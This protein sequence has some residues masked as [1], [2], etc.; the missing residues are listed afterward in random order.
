LPELPCDLHVH[1]VR[2]ACVEVPGMVVRTALVCHPGPTVGFRLETADASLAY[3]PDHE[4]ALAC[5]RFSTSPQWCSGY[6][7]ASGV[8]VLIHDAQYDEAEYRERIG[9]G[10]ST[11]RHALAFAELANARK[12]V[13]FHH[14]PSHD[15]DT[16]DVYFA[17]TVSDTVET[18]VAT[19][20]ETFLVAHGDT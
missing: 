10:H 1:D 11:L 9:W 6:D 19:E 8:D 16:L 17:G 12:L 2:E 15:D 3:L 18:V 20:G 14:D 7:L 5:A 13:L 4:P